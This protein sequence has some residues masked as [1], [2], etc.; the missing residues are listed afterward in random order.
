M[1]SKKTVVILGAGASMP[2]GF[3]SG[4]QLLQEAQSYETPDRLAG[5]INT[6]ARAGAEAFFAALR[7]TLDQS[8]DAM[9]ETLPPPV[10]EGGKGFIARFLLDREYDARTR[11]PKPHPDQKKLGYRWLPHLWNILDFRSLKDF[12]ATPIQF[13]TYNY[14]RSLEHALFEAITV[15]FPGSTPDQCR[16]AMDCIG[17]I[18][19]H[20]QLGPLPE[21][22]G[23]SG[24]VPYGGGGASGPT[25]KDCMI[26]TQAIQIVHEPTPQ[27]EPF[28]R[29]RAA[30]AW[31][32]RII[33]LGFGY[34]KTN[35]DRL[36]LKDCLRKE[37]NVF[38]CVLGFTEA[39]QLQ[40]LKPLFDG[41]NVTMGREE[42]DI[43]EFFRHNPH[44]LGRRQ[45]FLPLTTFIL[46]GLEP[47]SL[48][49]HRAV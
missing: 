34:S 6:P 5:F 14:D 48:V 22:A 18:H 13:V 29:A 3:P 32:D 42:Y 11:G 20:G 41:W 49:H 47:S 43:V 38:L 40:T 16:E 37:A 33:F 2:Y 35:V 46:A 17:P 10:V 31:A 39:Q 15:K 26:A 12:R 4:Q 30:I 45:L 36:L 27:S 9:L 7:G 1:L 21:L 28:I 8:I 24:T 19:L 44:A 25:D 23:A